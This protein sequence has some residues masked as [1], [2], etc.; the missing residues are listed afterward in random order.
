MKV[1]VSLVLMIKILS[2][3]KI[4]QGNVIALSDIELEIPQGEFIFIKGPSGSGKTTLLKIL[5]GL[6]K[7]TT[8]EVIV[9]GVKI[10][11]SKIK[12]IYKFRR[13]IGFI[14]PE[15]KLLKDRSVIDN[16]RFTLEVLGFPSHEIKV[17]VMEILRR[18]GLEK[19][20]KESVISLSNGEQ[21]LVSVARAVIKDPRIILADE[22]TS[23][24]DD[25]MKERVMGIFSE[26]NYNGTTIIF[27]TQ[28]ESLVQKYSYPAISLLN[29]KITNIEFY[30]KGNIQI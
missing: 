28:N 17:R 13:K 18:I 26:L 23:L 29:G 10:I 24:L 21:Q 15:F 27:A 2:V 4:Y 5:F 11:Q 16:L 30:N 19:K 14:S 9:D 1:R 20:A 3:S 22:P 25:N 12:N 6:E 7:P 8:G